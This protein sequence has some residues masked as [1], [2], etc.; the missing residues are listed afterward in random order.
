M[1]TGSHMVWG[2]KPLTGWEKRIAGSGD[3]KSHGLGWET[4]PRWEKGSLAQGTGSHMVWGG[5]TADW[6]GKRI[7]GSKSNVQ[8]RH[9]GRSGKGSDKEDA[10]LEKMIFIP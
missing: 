3:R 8:I 7:A 9:G 10:M 2:G 5:K 4:A 1:T 6:Q